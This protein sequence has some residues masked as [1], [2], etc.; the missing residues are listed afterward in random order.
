M[1][2][3]SDGVFE[4]M[5]NEEVMQTIIPFYEKGNVE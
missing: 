3:A 1:I 4:Y 2:I 5:T